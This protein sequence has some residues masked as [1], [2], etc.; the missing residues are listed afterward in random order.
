MKKKRRKVGKKKGKQVKMMNKTSVKYD[1]IFSFKQL[2]NEM[3]NQ[4]DKKKETLSFIL[5]QV[6]PRDYFKR[7]IEKKKQRVNV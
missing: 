7:K 6:E 4:I 3:S 1:E 5:N 2:F